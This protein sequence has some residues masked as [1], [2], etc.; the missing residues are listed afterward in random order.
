MFSQFLEGVKLSFCLKW[1]IC[2]LFLVGLVGILLFSVLLQ[3]WFCCL[4]VT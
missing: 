2:G 3:G 4:F 1:L